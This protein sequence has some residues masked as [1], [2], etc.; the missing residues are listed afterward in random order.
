MK[1]RFRDGFLEHPWGLIYAL[2]DS[3]L[4]RVRRFLVLPRQTAA[5]QLFRKAHSHITAI[6]GR[7]TVRSYGSTFPLL[8]GDSVCIEPGQPYEIINP[9]DMLA[10]VLDVQLG[11]YHGA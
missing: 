7:A 6:E 11:D 1:D 9:T 4:W 2:E 3:V 8:T 10:H 5:P